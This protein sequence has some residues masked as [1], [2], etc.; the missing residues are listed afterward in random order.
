MMG[1]EPSKETFPTDEDVGTLDAT[2][3]VK[4]RPPWRI[5]DGLGGC[6]IDE[7]VG[8]VVVDL[9]IKTKEMVKIMIS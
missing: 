9:P 7:I 4:S 6:S 5:G 2:D 1:E 8:I 3:G